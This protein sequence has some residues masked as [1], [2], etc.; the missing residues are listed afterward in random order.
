[1]PKRIPLD[2]HLFKL[3]LPSPVAPRRDPLDSLIPPAPST[4]PSQQSV[5][6]HLPG[7][8]VAHQAAPGNT[9]YE[10][11]SDGGVAASKDGKVE[12]SK[13]QIVRRAFD[14]YSDQVISLQRIQLVAVTSGK[15]K[16]KIG[17][18]ARLALDKFITSELKKYETQ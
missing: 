1:M 16:P 2:T 7:S 6:N 13:R 3:D 4:D 8:I 14:V 5:A 18:M 15:K 10:A 12:K 11:K 9:V 17:V